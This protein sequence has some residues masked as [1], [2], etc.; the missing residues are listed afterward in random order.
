MIEKVRFLLIMLFIVIVTIDCEVP[1]SDRDSLPLP[2]CHR[3]GMH[4]HAFEHCT[5]ED[6]KTYDNGDELKDKC[7]ENTNPIQ[8]CHCIDGTIWTQSD[9]SNGENRAE[10]EPKAN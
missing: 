4:L 9:E 1:V 2:P 7:L 8:S 10:S 6:G 5:C 3:Y